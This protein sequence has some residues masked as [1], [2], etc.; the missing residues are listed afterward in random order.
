MLIAGDSAG[1]KFEVFK[2]YRLH[3]DSI[4]RDYSTAVESIDVKQMDAK[5]QRLM[6][7]N[8]FKFRNR[9]YTT[10]LRIK[11]NEDLADEEYHQIRIKLSMH[12]DEPSRVEFEEI[13]SPHFFGYDKSNVPILSL[14]TRELPLEVNPIIF[15]ESEFGEKLLTKPQNSETNP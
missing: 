2:I 14:L 5:N 3:H 7:H 9:L 4:R 10:T 13:N 1:G 11:L 6:N 8:L 15:L 12:Y